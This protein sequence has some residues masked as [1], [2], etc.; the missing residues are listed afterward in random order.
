MKILDYMLIALSVVLGAG[1][2]LLLAALGSVTFINFG[3]PDPDI[4]LW[5]TILSFLFF[6]QH[7]LMVRRGFKERLS[8]RVS[9]R[10]HGAIYSIASG[11][12]LTVVVVFWQ[13]SATSVYVLEGVARW[14]VLGGMLFAAIVFVLSIVAL[15]TFDPLGLAPIRAHLHGVEPHSGPFVVRG[16]YRWVRHPLYACIL[17]V[18]WATPDLALDR[19][20]FN[21][22][23]TAWMYVGTVLEERDL[24]REFGEAYANYKKKVPMFVPW[25]GAAI[26]A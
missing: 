19:L 15:R 18:F 1:S 7:S 24:T 12:V 3:W 13:K 4:L 6:L 2:I 10:Y 26:D 21:V 9:T 11:I 8:K 22:L 20:L 17:V 23:W 16:P 5:D 14:I 25:R